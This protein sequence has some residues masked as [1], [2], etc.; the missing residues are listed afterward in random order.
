MRAKHLLS[1]ATVALALAAAPAFAQIG[2]GFNKIHQGAQSAGICQGALNQ[3][4]ED[5]VGAIAAKDAQAAMV[6]AMLTG[7]NDV[8][9]RA[10]VAAFSLGCK[11][12]SV[13]AAV[14]YYNDTAK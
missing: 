10:R 1:A 12:E 7:E 2:D 3:A 9:G 11:A 4:Q 13:A 14:K 5:K 6:G 8:R